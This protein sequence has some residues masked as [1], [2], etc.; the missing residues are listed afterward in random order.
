MVIKILIG[1]T[2]ARHWFPE[3]REPKDTDY[4]S[5]QEITDTDSKFCPSFKFLAEK[6]P[7]PIAP[8]HVLYTLKVSHA[9]WDGP[10]WDKTM[11]DIRFFQY[12]GLKLDEE[13][14]KILYQD[15]EKRYGKKP[16]YLNKSNDEFFSDGVKR[17]YVHD[18]L[19]KAVAFY[20]APLYERI[21]NDKEKAL[22]SY[23]LFERLAHSDKLKLAQEEIFVT[24][25]ERFLIPNDFHYVKKSAYMG[26]I[27]LLITSMTRGWFPKFLVENYLALTA[28][29]NY[30]FISKFNDA[31]KKGKINDCKRA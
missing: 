1:S 27:K 15:C 12:K 3:F 30:N 29:P 19:H 24:A 17:K 8:P 9:F 14:F 26:A 21:K 6:Y 23:G 5:E 2:A 18:D 22:T 11:Y 10:H 31:L 20:D 25:L 7:Q 28:T 16:A 13:L 4:I